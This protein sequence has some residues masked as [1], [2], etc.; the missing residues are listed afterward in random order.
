MKMTVSG[1]VTKVVDWF[2]VGPLRMIPRPTFRYAAVGGANALLNMFIFWASFNFLLRKQDT[3]FGVVVISA[4]ILAF[5]I[6]FVITFCIGFYLARNVAFSGSPLRGRV[7][8][9]RYGQVV[10]LNLAVNYFGLKLLVEGC[11]FYPSISYAAIQI[12]TIVFS[13]LAQRFY[14]FRHHNGC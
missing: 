7:Q 5:L 10:V 2:Y 12:I 9:F 3:D 8:L 14:T 13:Y 1:I 11:G 6:A 4:P